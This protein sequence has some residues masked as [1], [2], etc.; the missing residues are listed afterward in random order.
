LPA[1]GLK[2]VSC[3]AIENSSLDSRASVT[4][5][6]NN[7]AYYMAHIG[8]PEGKQYRS[9]HMSRQP[10]EEREKLWRVVYPVPAIVLCPGRDDAGAK[11]VVH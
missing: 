4:T 10:F 2:Y 9:S 11:A 1:N 7:V 8:M 5:I 6:I 3:L